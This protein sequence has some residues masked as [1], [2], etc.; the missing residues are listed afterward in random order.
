MWAILEA[1]GLDPARIVHLVGKGTPTSESDSIIQCL[2]DGPIDVDKIS[3]LQQD[4]ACSHVRYGAGIDW[5][6]LLRH[7]IVLLPSDYPK[8]KMSKVGVLTGGITAA[9]SVITA[10]YY[11]FTRVYWHRVNRAI[12]AMISD[13]MRRLLSGDSPLLSFEEFIEANINASDWEALSWISDRLDEAIRKGVLPSA[14]HRPIGNAIRGIIDGSRQ[15][16]KRLITFWPNPENAQ[17]TECHN[18]LMSL[19]RPQLE[20]VRGELLTLIASRTGADWI[21][22]Q[23]VLVDAPFGR[24]ERDALATIWVLDPRSGTLSDLA[25]TSPIANG[26]YAE[27]QS[28][29]KRSRIFVSPRLR[30]QCQDMQN[31]ES[32]IVEHILNLSRRT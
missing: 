14:N 26:V 22:D 5:E 2:L 6:G 8:V 25:K 3:Y 13:A 7:L 11:M 10:R 15:L 32:E 28:L 18:F 17:Y 21:Q 20:Q 29:A 4:S 12:M 24:K 27:F 1:D 23:E 30:D 9:E 19:S 31:L 16:Y